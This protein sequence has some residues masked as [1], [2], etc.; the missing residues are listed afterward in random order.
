MAADRPVL[1]AGGGIGGLALALA[2][3]QAGRSSVVL[4]RRITPAT[5]GAGSQIGPNGVHVLR[6]LGI[7]DAL[8]AFVGEP[9]RLE[10]RDGPSARTLAELPLGHWMAG[11]HGAPYWVV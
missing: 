6:R 2:L 5:E 9:E 7:A 11:R 10:V 8:L 1:I 4:E 3:A